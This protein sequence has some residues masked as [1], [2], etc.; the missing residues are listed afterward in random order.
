MSILHRITNRMLWMNRTRTLVTV[1]G[2]M[3]SMALFVAV[4]EGAYSGLA[5]L[6]S[7]TGSEEGFWEGAY[8]DADRAAADAAAAQR[9]VK[10]TA[11][12][13]RVG[14]ETDSAEDR[15]LLVIDAAQEPESKLLGLQLTEGRLPETEGELLLPLSFF[16]GADQTPDPSGFRARYAVGE[17]LT[18]PLD[19]GERT[20]TIVGYYNPLY[21]ELT[22]TVPYPD[23]YALTAGQGSGSYT[24]L[25]TLH[26][27][28]LFNR[29]AESQTTHL[30]SH[31][32]LLR[33]DGVDDGS[34]F[35]AMLYGF[36]AILAI[37]IMFGSISLIYNAFSISVSERTRQYG[38]LKS[39][40]ATKKQ[41]R[42]MVL[43]EAWLMSLI[44]VVPGLGLGLAGIGVTLWAIAPIFDKMLTLASGYRMQLVFHPLSCGIAALLCIGTTLISA[45]IPAKRA[46]RLNAIEA[47]RQSADVRLSPREVKTA[48]LTEKLFG[49][50]GTMASKNFKRNRKR[51]RATVVSLAMSVILFIS[52]STLTMY[53]QDSVFSAV[54]SDP[55]DLVFSHPEGD[56]AAQ[57]ALFHRLRNAEHITGGFYEYYTD[58]LSRLGESNLTD[59]YLQ[60]SY[61]SGYD[62]KD[63]TEVH[64]LFTDDETFDRLC[65]QSGIDPKPYYEDDGHALLLS[66]RLL[67]RIDDKKI[68]YDIFKP[69]VFPCEI[70]TIPDTAPDGMR[71]ITPELPNI[72][73]SV[74][75]ETDD[76]LAYYPSDAMNALYEAGSIE[77][78]WSRE[79]DAADVFD[80]AL[81]ELRPV[82]HESLTIDGVADGTGFPEYPYQ[83]VVLF[84]ASRMASVPDTTHGAYMSFFVSDSA[85]AEQELR[86]IL[87]E[88]GI[89]GNFSLFN[90][91]ESRETERL[92]ILVLNVF[93]YGF[94]TLISLIAVANVFNTISTNILL[95]RREFAM[96]R[97]IGLGQRGLRSM[98]N[99]ECIIYGAKALLWG[100]PIS[101]LVSVA[102]WRVASGPEELAFRIPWHS[103]AIAVGSVF[104]VVFATMLYAMH[105]IKRDNPIDALKNEN[106]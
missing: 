82:L 21:R 72:D 23:G 53:L 84:P 58:R 51:Y 41:I 91:A 31:T 81:I 8:I 94:I 50:S 9:E 79:L 52:A 62:E 67:I 88:C 44:G 98:M 92:L 64:F 59:D 43:H 96:L 22:R 36:V 105:K 6:R 1:I 28:L 87:A 27:P 106:L 85:A 38:I 70:E 56:L 54:G 76:L 20:Y 33:Y 69:G 34:L 19:T 11:L 35:M 61:F 40:G 90:L 15:P 101:A 104:A 30:I 17:T 3:L 37:L 95:R 100:L 99:L 18:V 13:E 63:M 75:G 39:V 49:F 102:I 32:S 66:N 25:F 77:K 29:F 97:S 74:F 16:Y 12:L 14:V 48:K 65:R 83:V 78:I 42:R 86:D 24:V 73:P 55:A 10:E 4:F 93:A 80:P 45:W 46:M 71:R 5:Y 26:T 68:R 57:D 2:I 60:Y 7:V 47:I 89:K 103:V